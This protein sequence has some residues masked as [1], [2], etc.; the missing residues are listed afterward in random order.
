MFR[1]SNFDQ[2][3]ADSDGVGDVCDDFPYDPNYS[4]DTDEDSM[5]DEWE[6]DYFSDLNEIG[7]GDPDGDGLIN[8]DEYTAG[9][10]PNN[11]DSDNDGLSDGMEVNILDTKPLLSDTDGNGIPDGDEDNDGDGFTN[12]QELQ[13]DSDPIDPYSRC[14]KALP[15]LM[16]LLE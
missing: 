8:V 7:S 2:S 14:T 6:Q 11:P 10:A 9:A 4:T 1:Y 15:W 13:C 16:L 3:D 5:P 12:I